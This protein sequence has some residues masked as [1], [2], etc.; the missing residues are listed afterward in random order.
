MEPH[1]GIGASTPRPKEAQTRRVQDRKAETERR[2]DDDGSEDV[3]KNVA[4]DHS[5]VRAAADA[6]RFNILLIADREN[7]RAHDSCIRRNGGNADGEDQVKNARSE[8]G[9][10][11]DCQ[12]NAR[13]REHHVHEAHDDRVG[14]SAVE[15]CETAEQ[16]ADQQRNTD[17]GEAD[18]KRDA[19]TVDDA[20][21]HV[22]AKVIRTERVLGAGRQVH[23]GQILRSIVIG[24]EL[25]GENRDQNKNDDDDHADDGKLVFEKA[26]H[27]A[28][29][30]L[31][32][33]LFRHASSRPFCGRSRKFSGR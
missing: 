32:F 6:R 15:A 18:E 13:H 23:A 12:Q 28:G 3:R 10:N 5:R 16:R 31:P 17:G 14:L 30:F 25:V 26:A 7:G 24:R 33:F 11:N 8:D 27:R 21:E 4:Q 22:A 9:R 19:R 29:F 2:L 20:A 1:S